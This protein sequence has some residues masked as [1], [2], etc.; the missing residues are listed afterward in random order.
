MP[1]MM[2]D[3]IDRYERGADLAHRIIDGLSSVEL[4]APPPQGAPGAWTL[5]QIVIHL[6]DS[7]LI[8][9]HRMRRV[10]AEDL[11]LLIGYDENRFVARLDY[12]HADA[13]LAADA[14]RLNRMMLVPR[15]RS[16]RSEDFDRAGIHNE[17][18][19]VTLAEFVRSYADHSEHHARFAAE[20]RRLMGK[21]MA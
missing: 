20:K 16:L 11:P 4:H 17:H 14:Y 9:V 12:E 3:L 19:R 18:G 13:R 8:G 10:I 15:L 2:S 5:Q 21:P 7:D 6:W 1:G